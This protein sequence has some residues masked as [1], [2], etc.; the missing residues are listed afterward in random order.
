MSE[1]IIHGY[2]LL[3]PLQNRDAGFSRWT[4]AKKAGKAYF[5]KEFLDPVYPQDEKIGA[6][7]MEARRKACLEFEKTRTAVYSAVNEASDGNV[8]RVSEFFRMG[9]RYYIAMRRV[10]G[11]TLSLPE[12]IALPLPARMH[13]CCV[14]AHGIACLHRRKVVHADIKDRNILVRKTDAGTYTAKLIDFDCSFLEDQPPR[15]ESELGGDQIYLSPE[16]CLFLCGE[17]AELTTKMDVFSLGIL[18]HQYLTGYVPGFDAGEYDYLHE[19]VL[20][21]HGAVVSDRIPRVWR[22]VLEKM[23]LAEPDKRCSM[24]EVCRTVIP[25]YRT[26]EASNGPGGPGADPAENT[27]GKTA[28]AGKGEAADDMAERM[29]R[30][31][32][33]MGGAL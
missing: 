1:E 3:E 20:D 32:F 4:Y 2:Q 23:L 6:V 8:V 10:L 25:G 19:S 26:P 15:N 5:L 12:I 21:G 7:Q 33:R 17:E 29:A 13:L 31:G 27:G 28:D 14:I 11:Q 30:G 22:P 18:F 16:A 9:P 24:E